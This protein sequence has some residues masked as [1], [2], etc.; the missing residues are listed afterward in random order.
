MEEEPKNAVVLTHSYSCDSRARSNYKHI[1]SASPN[2]ASLRNSKSEAHP[3]HS[4][5]CLLSA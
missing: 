1:A 4:Y 3:T 5:Y 2:G